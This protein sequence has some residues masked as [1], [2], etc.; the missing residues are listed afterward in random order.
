MEAKMAD[1][2]MREMDLDDKISIKG[3]LARYGVPPRR[4]WQ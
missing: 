3:K 4:P 2:R 1:P